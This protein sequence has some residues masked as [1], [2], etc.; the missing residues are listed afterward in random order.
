MRIFLPYNVAEN[1]QLSKFVSRLNKIQDSQIQGYTLHSNPN[2]KGCLTKSCKDSVEGAEYNIKDNQLWEMDRYFSPVCF[3]RQKI[4][5]DKEEILG[6]FVNPACLEPFQTNNEIKSTINKCDLLLLIPGYLSNPT[7]LIN[8]KHS[9]GNKLNECIKQV[10][11]AEFAGEY[12]RDNTRVT[13]ESITLA[14]CSCNYGEYKN[15]DVVKCKQIGNIKYQPA[16]ANLLVH[17]QTD[18]CIVEIYIPNIA[19][20]AQRV[21]SNYCGNNLMLLKEDK[22]ISLEEYLESYGISA[23][24]GKRSMVFVQEKID[25]ANL[26]NLL[27]NE[28]TPMGNIM[29]KHFKDIISNNLAQYDTAKVYA[30]TTTMVEIVKKYTPNL[31]LRIESQAI[32]IFFVEMLLL[33][34]AAVSK[35]YQKVKKSV[36][37][38]RKNPYSK[39]TKEIINELTLEMSH[40]IDFADYNQFYYP[41]VRVSAEKVAEAFGINYIISKFEE[42]KALLQQMVN[43]HTKKVNEKENKIK[44][45]LLLIISL[46]S[47]INVSALFIRSV[48]D[49]GADAF[50]Y[51]ISITAVLSGIIIYIIAKKIVRRSLKNVYSKRLKKPNEK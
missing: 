45:S 16:I 19:V 43:S 2:I 15:C 28:E 25:D 7:N 40:A 38:E 49:L 51:W 21:L 1:A 48:F 14:S 27:V 41:T 39:S 10:A 47:G 44:N 5:Q 34:D 12:I 11:D 42:N 3:Y 23:Y 32:E 8:I 6:Y 33:Q 35:M 24:G 50:S 29:G 17:N 46:F 37:D 30:S 22:V 31:F 9:V 36:V 13:L 20:S 4:Q 26:L 18:L